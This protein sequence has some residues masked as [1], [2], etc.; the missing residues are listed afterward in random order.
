MKFVP[1]NEIL[2]YEEMLPV[3]NLSILSGIRKVRLA[4]GKP[5]VKKGIISFIE[6]LCQVDGLE[7]IVLTTNGVLLRKFARPLRECGIFR[8]NDGYAEAGKISP[9]Y[10]AG[11][12]CAGLGGVTP[13][14]SMWLS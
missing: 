2:T 4:G 14:R 6:C 13:S 9:D 1:H 11:L 12:F 8:V 10:Q 5:Q 3:V 7:E